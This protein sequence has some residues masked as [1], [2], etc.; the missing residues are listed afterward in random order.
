MPAL[1]DGA[2][3]D[4]AVA[5]VGG[6]S[7]AAGLFSGFA[8]QRHPAVGAEP[9]GG[10][11]VGH[12]IPGWSTAR[13]RSC[14]QDEW[15]QV[16]EAE[17]ISAG[18]DYPGVGPEHAHLSDIGRAGYHPVTDEEVLDAF[19]TLPRTEGI[20]PALESAH[21]LAWSSAERESWPG[22]PC[23][24]NLSGRGDKDVEQVSGILG[25]AAGATGACGEGAAGLS[26]PTCAPAATPGAS[27]SSPTS[28]AASTPAG[29]TCCAAAPTPGPTRSRSASRSATR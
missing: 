15:G 6:G 24:V 21:A 29:S 28:P 20:I 5:C 14:M 11:A 16:Q 22:R 4:V 23:C 10:A 3:P 18:L 8:D 12:G 2:D 27:C 9:A 19:V 26:R 13:S 25:P 7:N 1:L 17:S